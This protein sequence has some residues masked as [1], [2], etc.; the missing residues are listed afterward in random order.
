[1]KAMLIPIGR[2]A[3]VFVALALLIL[4]GCS[5]PPDARTAQTIIASH[6]K[7]VLDPN[8]SVT[9]D[10]FTFGD[11]FTR[12]DPDGIKRKYFPCHATYTTVAA[13]GKTNKGE[14][15]DGDFALNQR[16]EWMIITRTP[17]K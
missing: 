13:R 9:V 15:W 1:M 8:V 11:A 7:S 17:L 4:L 14:V 5:R 12:T 10:T 3:S 16:N 6:V 2:W